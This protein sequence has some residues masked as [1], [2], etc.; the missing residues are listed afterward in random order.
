MRG[1]KVKIR[2]QENR[3]GTAPKFVLALQG[4]ATRPHCGVH[5]LAKRATPSGEVC[6][7]IH[8]V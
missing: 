6:Q 7:W 3:K 2:T 1:Q 5:S 8:R 4:C